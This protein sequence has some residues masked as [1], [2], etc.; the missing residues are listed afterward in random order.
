[1]GSNFLNS[2]L[3]ARRWLQGL[4]AVPL[5]LSAHGDPSA[6]CSLWGSLWGSVAALCG[7]G[8]DRHRPG[9]Q[10]G[11][12]A[13]QASIVPLNHQSDNTPP[14]RWLAG[15]V[16]MQQNSPVHPNPS[17]GTARNPESTRDLTISDL[18]L[19]SGCHSQGAK[20]PETM[21]RVRADLSCW[22]V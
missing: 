17:L 19:D 22:L 8:G 11:P 14:L 9:V 10:L 16:I 1:M 4:V 21:T 20:L 7:A 3:V 12:P 18:R 15:L 2:Y 6:V 5:L 13:W